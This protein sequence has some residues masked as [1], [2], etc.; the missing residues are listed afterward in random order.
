MPFQAG[1]ARVKGCLELPQPY[2]CINV[3]IFQI[4]LLT[5]FYHKPVNRKNPSFCQILRRQ[6]Q[7]ILKSSVSDLLSLLLVASGSVTLVAAEAVTLWRAS[8]VLPPINDVLFTLSLCL[9]R[10]SKQFLTATQ[11][12]KRRNE[13]ARN[14]IFFQN[15]I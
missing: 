1:Q 9:C 14:Y 13:N 5:H 6:L 7:L 8:W 2:S 3:F 4:S 15:Y 10:H 12:T 11:Q